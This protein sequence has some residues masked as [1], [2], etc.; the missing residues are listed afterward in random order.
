MTGCVS[1]S[2]S[3]SPYRASRPSLTPLLPL[4]AQN[5]AFIFYSQYT[6]AQLLVPAGFLLE[7]LSQPGFEER[8]VFK[9]YSAKSASLAVL[10]PPLNLH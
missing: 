2:L 10:E 4:D 8:F 9:K 3:L 1:R 6:E 5:E 7:N